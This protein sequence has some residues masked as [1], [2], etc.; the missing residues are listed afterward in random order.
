MRSAEI[1][2]D[3]FG[4]TQENVH[5]VVRGLT[6]GQLAERIAPDANSIAWLIW[7]LARVQDDFGPAFFAGVEV[8]VGFGCLV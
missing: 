5:A 3:G 2:V 6:A 7:H 1:L 8:L 4:R